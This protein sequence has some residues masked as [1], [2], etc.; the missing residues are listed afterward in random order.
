[1]NLNSENVSC[2]IIS[3]DNGILSGNEVACRVF[4]KNDKSI[5]YTEQ[6]IDSETLNNG[7]VIANIFGDKSS[8]LPAERTALNFLQR[9]S[10]VASITNEYVKLVKNI[11]IFDTRK[12]IPGWRTLD[13]YAVKCG[14][15]NNHRMNLGDGLLIKDNHISAANKQGISIKKLVEKSRNNSPKN[16]KIEIEVDS[17]DLLK[18]V[19]ETNVDIIMLDNMTDKM[20]KKSIDITRGRKIIEVS[21]NVDKERLVELDNIMGIDIVSIGRITHSAKALDI[22]LVI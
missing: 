22:S 19:V 1:M 21:G 2:K 4:Q 16:L 11:S 9:M 15:G 7:T 18:E 5:D 17:L 13:K 3:K 20:I 6:T 14:G 8:I 10:G 12:T